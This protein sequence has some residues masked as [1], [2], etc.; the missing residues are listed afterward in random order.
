MIYTRGSRDDWDRWAEIADD[1][2]LRWS[3]MLPLMKKVRSFY[4]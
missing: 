2:G 3:N 1:E 4:I